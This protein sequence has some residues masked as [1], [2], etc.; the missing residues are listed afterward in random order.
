VSEAITWFFE[1]EPEGIILE[2]DCFPT[3]TFFR[4]ASQAL[5]RFRDDHTILSINGCS[6]G[7]ENRASN[8][9]FASRYMNMWG[10]ATWRR[11]MLLVDYDMASWKK[12]R[13]PILKLA[14]LLSLRP[15]STDLWWII[16]L[17]MRFERTALGQVN[18]WDFQWVW[19]GIQH[20]KTVVVPPLNLVRNLGFHEDATHT[21]IANEYLAELPLQ[22][23]KEDL[24]IPEELQLIDDFETHYVRHRWFSMS[25]KGRKGHLNRAWHLSIRH[26]LQRQMV[27]TP[28]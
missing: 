20:K 9:A 15:I 24:L 25:P 5:E 26:L 19:T 2:D 1:N 4:F 3:H 12:C 17:A 23:S 7:F 10:W 27:N 14:A 21:T 6:L 18:T 28:P 16:E 11:S 8:E 13:V 22:E